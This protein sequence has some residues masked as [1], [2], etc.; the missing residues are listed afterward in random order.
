MSLLL[1]PYSDLR[2]AAQL[3]PLFEEQRRVLL[4][5]ACDPGKFRPP[6]AKKKFFFADRGRY[7]V[8]TLRP[9][10]EL[11]EFAEAVTGRRLKHAWTRLYRLRHR[12]YSLHL[13]DAL[14]RIES[15]VELML[16]LSRELCSAPVIWSTGLQVPQIPGLLAL[17]ERTPAAHRYDRYLPAS[18]GRATV[19]R[20]RAA[21]A[22]DD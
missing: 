6:P 18:V 16:D 11:H 10:A 8:S 1:P 21:F 7:E 4:P 15:G 5:A 2:V 20:L 19:L 13:D 17:V 14:T 22:S 12:S 3:R 9:A